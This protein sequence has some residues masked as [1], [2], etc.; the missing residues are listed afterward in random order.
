MV[1]PL[2]PGYI[3]QINEL[4]KL[5]SSK[6][7]L[8]AWANDLMY[9][10]IAVLASKDTSKDMPDYDETIDYKYIP[11]YD[12]S[13]KTSVAPSMKPIDSGWYD[14]GE[15]L[16]KLEKAVSEHVDKI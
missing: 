12:I 1:T 8:T 2:H 10:Q 15:R 7:H 5:C 4:K 3:D 16:G 13:S 11:L 14:L 6:D 9:Q